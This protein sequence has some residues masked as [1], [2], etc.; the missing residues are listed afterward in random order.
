MLKDY[1][2]PQGKSNPKLKQNAKKLLEKKKKKEKHLDTLM[3]SQITLDKVGF[4]LGLDNPEANKAMSEAK[5]VESEIWDKMRE[6]NVEENYNEI[7]DKNKEYE[8]A[9][10]EERNYKVEIDKE[11]LE[12][13]IYF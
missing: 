2:L 7:V 8:D 13:G 11:I 12:K 9:F 3:F 10:E 4:N 5:Q 6:M 1:K